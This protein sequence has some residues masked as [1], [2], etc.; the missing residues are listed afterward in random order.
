MILLLKYIQVKGQIHNLSKQM[1]ELIC[2]DTEKMLDISLIDN[3]LERLAGTLNRYNSQQRQTVASALRHEEYLK[4]SVANISHDL[5]TP[6]TVILGHLQLLKKEDLPKEQENRVETILNKAERMK[7]LI[8]I[9]YN[10]AVLDTEC[11][12][13]QR[14]KFNFTNLL[15]NLITENSPALEQKNICPEIN[16]PEFSVF[17]FSDRNMVERILQNL[18]TNAIRYTNGNIKINLEQQARNKICFSIENSVSNVSEID[19]SRL[20]ERFYMADKSRRGGGT[21]LGLAVVKA[22]VEKLG[23]SVKANLQSDT[24]VI[25]LEL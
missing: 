17:A 21:G 5:R 22:L 14:E 13:T 19:V 6:L 8:E 1:E 23:G 9:F 20:F 10:L 2:K 7:E 24:L 11:T 16:L 4:E 3:D 25:I 18:L 12:S 15:I